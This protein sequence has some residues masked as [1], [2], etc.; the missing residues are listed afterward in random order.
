MIALPWALRE[1]EAEAPKRKHI[2]YRHYHLQKRCYQHRGGTPAKK[3]ERCEKEVQ[4]K[5]EGERGKGREER[6][7]DAREEGKRRGQ[8]SGPGRR[9]ERIEI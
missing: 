1:R 9:T 7:K 6:K 2:R 3:G 4:E 5:S 8:A